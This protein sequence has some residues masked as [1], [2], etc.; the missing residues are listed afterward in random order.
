M[1]RP[2]PSDQAPPPPPPPPARDPAVV[3]LVAGLV[4]IALSVAATVTSIWGTDPVVSRTA[5][6]VLAI[7]GTA[8]MISAA[9][10][11]RPKPPR[12]AESC[13]EEEQPAQES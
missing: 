6:I 9:G 4:P 2:R 11:V 3:L 5:W 8:T 1:N 13:R 12:P 7:V 10:S